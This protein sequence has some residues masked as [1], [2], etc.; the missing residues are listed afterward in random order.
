MIGRIYEPRSHYYCEIQSF[1]FCTV[2]LSPKIVH[3]R[4]VI[5]VFKIKTSWFQVLTKLKV[6]DRESY[7]SDKHVRSY[8]PNKLKKDEI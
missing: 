3:C 8:F 4:L 2:V 7:D 1:V 6:L 5:Q